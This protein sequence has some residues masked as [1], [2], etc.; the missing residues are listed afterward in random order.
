MAR[1]GSE[2]CFPHSPHPTSQSHSRCPT[3]ELVSLWGDTRKTPNIS[4][5]GKINRHG[6]GSVQSEEDRP[7]SGC[8]VTPSQ[9]ETGGAGGDRIHLR[10][11]KGVRSLLNTL[12]GSYGQDNKGETVCQKAVMEG[13]STGGGEEAWEQMQFSFF[14]TCAWV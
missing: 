9:V 7:I 12:Q 1:M 10:Q 8:G 4:A 6:V 5:E 3:L 11:S 13:S 14:G 2:E